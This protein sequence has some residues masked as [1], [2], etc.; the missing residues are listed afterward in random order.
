MGVLHVLPPI[1]KRNA[2]GFFSSLVSSLLILHLLL[3]V[4]TSSCGMRLIP[5]NCIL[6]LQVVRQVEN[7]FEYPLYYSKTGK[8]QHSNQSKISYIVLTLTNSRQSKRR[9]HLAV[10]RAS[11]HIIKQ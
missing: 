5:V 10:V 1:F 3:F 4:S 9:N 8:F 11:Y 7:R 2:F 6:C